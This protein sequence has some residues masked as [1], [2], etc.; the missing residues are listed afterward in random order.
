MADKRSKEEIERDIL[1][2]NLETSRLALERQKEDNQ[3]F[4]QSR[5][6]RTR[7]NK[8]RQLQLAQQAANTAAQQA[9]CLHRQGG[10]PDDV[11]EGDGKSALTLSRIFFSNNFLIQCP[12]CDL[13]L[14]RPHPALK[15]KKL[16]DGETVAQRDERIKKY[17]EDLTHYN[18]L[19]A[20]AKS[21]KLKPMLGPTWEFADEDGTPFVPELR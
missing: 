6:Q 13:A 14:Q 18:I 11:F 1:E 9:I 5:E 19:L 10:G 3:I 2:T 20:Q 17:N 16:R 8:Q 7:Q 12:R 21:N 4:T 15:S